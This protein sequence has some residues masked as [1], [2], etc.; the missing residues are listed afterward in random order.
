VLVERPVKKGDEI[1]VG[2]VSGTVVEIGLRATRIVT[3]DEVTM[4]IPNMELIA[5]RVVNQSVPS[6]R[7]RARVRVGVAYDSN[8]DLVRDTLLE[9]AANHP[10]V[11]ENPAPAVRLEAFADSSLNFALL[12][13][14][15][16]AQS[17]DEITSDIRLA[18]L[19]AFRERGISI[20]YPHH[21][22]HLTS[23]K[24][25]A[26]DKPRSAPATLSAPEPDK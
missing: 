18:I 23:D 20:P 12:C 11:L 22:V 5:G 7:I 17:D 16:N 21:E 2:D 3:R 19:F 8:V 26:T 6:P 9:V 14:L 25:S 24:P 15:P 13:W 10:N 1:Q 4:I